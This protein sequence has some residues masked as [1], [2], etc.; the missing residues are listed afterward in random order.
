M[1]VVGVV[2]QLLR[3]VGVGVLLR[4]R[5]LQ[6]AL[7]EV[8]QGVEGGVVAGRRGGGRAGRGGRGRG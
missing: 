3:E 7:A 5:E 2:V 4:V 8:V 6:R 1:V